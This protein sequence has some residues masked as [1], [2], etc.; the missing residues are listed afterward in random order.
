MY[1][2]LLQENRFLQGG[3]SGKPILGSTKFFFIFKNYHHTT[4]IFIILSIKLALR[5]L[6]LQVNRP[7]EQLIV[8]VVGCFC[9]NIIFLNSKP[10]TRQINV[11]TEE[12]IIAI[13][14]ISIRHLSQLLDR[15]P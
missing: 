13:A 8:A 7:S 3:E 10:V 14:E 1:L 12:N 11:H 5:A 15:F 6:Y 2:H 4:K 9:T